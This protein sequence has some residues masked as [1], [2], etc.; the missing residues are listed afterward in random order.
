MRI[1]AMLTDNKEN[2]DHYLKHGFYK[3]EKLNVR[4]FKF[5][6]D[7]ALGSRGACLLKPYKDKPQQGFLLSSPDYFDSVAVLM[8][9]NGFQMNTH[10]I[11]DSAV[12]QLLMT[13][14]KYF[15]NHCLSDRKSTRLNSSH[16]Q[17]SRMPSSA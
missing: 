11:G 15:P 16:I 12:R 5:Y 13:Y 1:Y 6:A 14:S 9:E 3:T 2:L 10:A 8:N 7:G 17:K 4:S